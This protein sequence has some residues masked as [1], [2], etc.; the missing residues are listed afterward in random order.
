MPVNH[1][2]D[3]NPSVLTIA[4]AGIISCENFFLKNIFS[5]PWNHQKNLGLLMFSKEITLPRFKISLVKMEHCLET[6]PIL[7]AMKIYLSYFEKHCLHIRPK[8][9]RVSTLKLSAATVARRLISSSIT[10]FHKGTTCWDVLVLNKRFPLLSLISSPHPR[11]LK[12]EAAIFTMPQKQYYRW[13]KDIEALRNT[14][15]H[16]HKYAKLGRPDPFIFQ[17]AHKRVGY[18]RLI[19]NH[20]C[21]SWYMSNGPDNCSHQK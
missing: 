11:H 7:S 18:A 15:F 17:E 21:G 3:L 2:C 9:V 19:M 10:L 8:L 5:F 12:V 20:Y 16:L 14:A 6:I 13:P 1:R 4:I